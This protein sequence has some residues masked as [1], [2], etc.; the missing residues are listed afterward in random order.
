MRGAIFIYS[1]VSRC[2]QKI[3][4]ISLTSR[5]HMCM[6]FLT[7]CIH[8]AIIRFCPLV[9]TYMIRFPVLLKKGADIFF[10]HCLVLAVASACVSR[11]LNSLSPLQQN[12]TISTHK[13]Y[14]P[15]HMPPL[16][17]L[18]GLYL[19]GIYPRVHISLTFGRPVNE[20]WIVALKSSRPS[21][22]F[23]LPPLPSPTHPSPLPC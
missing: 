6:Y 4:V 20:Y 17:H 9:C 3:N 18:F 14:C 2:E 15:L 7:V 21:P 10:F 1:F 5:L 19:H 12:I 11:T 23:P 13:I 8:E 22:P 16:T